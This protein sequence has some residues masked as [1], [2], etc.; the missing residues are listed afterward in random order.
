[1]RFRF[2]L[3]FAC[4]SLLLSC[5]NDEPQVAFYFSAH[6]DDW[7]LFM[8]ERA[9]ADIQDKNT[10]SVFFLTT[11]GDA[12]MGMTAS[13]GA[14]VP[15][16]KAR[17]RGYINALKWAEKPIVKID[18]A[19]RSLYPLEDYVLN[20]VVV[21]GHVIKKFETE[22]SIAYLFYLPDGFPD[23]QYQWSLQKLYNGEIQNMPTID[24]TAMYVDWKDL[25]STVKT[26]LN[27]EANGYENI[28]INLPERDT[29]LNP[30]DHSDHW[31]SSLLGE[32]ASEKL[33]PKKRYYREFAM[34]DL[35]TN[36]DGKAVDIKRFLFSAN[37][38]SK[39]AAGYSSPWNDH[40]LAWVV[41]SYYREE[42]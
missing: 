32:M 10:K 42:R 21:N 37:A 26:L 11:T 24:S 16:F 34:T 40:H 13:E 19:G 12:G 39:E 20:E 14:N 31:Y 15:Y 9:Y 8:G 5:A 1:M 38:A 35:I 27:K 28:W 25:A 2:V 41:R 4:F 18:S 33:R 17:E 36:L 22:Q 6:P 7:Q 29:L 23:G 30:E 3:T